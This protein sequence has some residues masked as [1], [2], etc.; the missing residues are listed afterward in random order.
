MKWS[1]HATMLDTI[2]VGEVIPLIRMI[3]II[4]VI[5]NFINSIRP[6]VES[7]CAQVRHLVK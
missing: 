7:L 6:R 4:L 1:D 5:A 2:M 3:S